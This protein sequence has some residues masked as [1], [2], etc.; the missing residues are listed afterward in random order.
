MRHL[1]PGVLRGEAQPGELKGTI[2]EKCSVKIAQK[3]VVRKS[4]GSDSSSL[5]NKS[6]LPS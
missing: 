2:F 1:S 3:Y 5:R 4:G 6:R